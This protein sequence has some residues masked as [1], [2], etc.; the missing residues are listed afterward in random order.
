MS[1]PYNK[2][3]RISFIKGCLACSVAVTIQVALT[4]GNCETI[5]KMFLKYVPQSSTKHEQHQNTLITG[6]LPILR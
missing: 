4:K 3:K 1:N 6:N 5:D 2:Q